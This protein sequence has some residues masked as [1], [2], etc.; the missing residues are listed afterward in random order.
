MKKKGFLLA[1]L[2]VLFAFSLAIAACSHVKTPQVEVETGGVPC[3]EFEITAPALQAEGVG[4]NPLICW[5]AE[6]N[7][8]KYVVS[9]CK[10]T[11]FSDIAAE[12]V[13]KE[14]SVTLSETLAYST[15]YYIRIFAVKS[16]E[17]GNDIILSYASSVFTTLADHD[18]PVPDNSR[19]R[20]IHDFENFEDDSELQNFFTVHTGG[21]SLIPTLA[22]GEGADGSTAMRL[23]YT[24]EGNGWS[25]VQ[26]INP[27]D[28]KNWSGAT[29]IRL[30]ISSPGNGGVLSVSIG[31][32]GYQTWK[33]SVTLN[34]K[35]AA[36]VSIPFSAFEDSGGGDG[37][38]D[39]TGIVRLWF[40][41]K[42]NAASEV[43]L[44]NISIGSD[45]LHSE[46]TRSVFEQGDVM[47]VGMYDDFE[48]Y[49]SADAVKE[50]YFFNLIDPDSI[51]LE[52][53][54]AFS[55]EQMLGFVPNEASVA[56]GVRFGGKADFSDIVSMRFKASAGSYSVQFVSGSNVMVASVLAV[57]NGE[58]VGVNLDELD[59]R[60]PS[61]MKMTLDLVDYIQIVVNGKKNQTVYIDDIEFSAERFVPADHSAPRTL[62]DFENYADDTALQGE[63]YANASG[64]A[65]T[66]TLA[67]GEGAQG[68]TAMQVR[69]GANTA[70][71][72]ALQS[73]LSDGRNIWVGAEGIR[74]WIDGG[75]SGITV[76]VRI[77][78]T[79]NDLRAKL[80]LNAK[81]GQYVSI[82]F[83]AFD[84]NAGSRPSDFSSVSVLW[85]YVSGAEN[86]TF[87][88]D[89]ISIGSGEGY[90]ADT[91]DSVTNPP[92][93]SAEGI[94]EDFEGYSAAGDVTGKWTVSGS[95]AP[96]L[97]TKNESQ[98]LKFYATKEFSAAASGYGLS[99]Y[100]FTDING[101][102]FRLGIFYGQGASSATVTVR[103]GSEGNYYTVNKLFFEM[104]NNN[105]TYMV[106]DF[107]GMTLA[108]G[109]AGELDSSAIDFLEISVSGFT[110]VVDF[111]ID[112]LE[113][114]TDAVG[115]KG[116][117]FTSDFS[118]DSTQNW[119]NAVIANNTAT[120]SSGSLQ[121][122]NSSWA[123]YQNTYALRFRV[124][125]QN[126]V[127]IS[128][129]TL[130]GS[131]DG[132]TATIPIGE[133]G[134][135]EFIVYY[136]QM[137]VRNAMY[138]SM[139]FY[140]IQM[141]VTF[142]TGGGSAE[143]SS[144]ELLIG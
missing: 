92:K 78:D 68:S 91:R 84:V 55:G 20:V 53:G 3:G 38:W 5:T 131:G 56:F 22:K 2:G 51:A 14:T 31:K 7:A 27:A 65:L 6:R 29:G 45:E 110:G 46:D 125:T 134:E 102:R 140:Y 71:W 74:F 26:S 114:Y 16:D 57:S 9:L 79:A 143:F 139:K 123:N 41:Y 80:T 127:S 97:V 40:Y 10:D 21:D 101:F 19:T 81:E 63:F 121:Y 99:G 52:S 85:L 48:S 44:D 90:D 128:A 50:R 23:T 39:M 24:P 17:N 60:D 106:C 82:P 77:G 75:G 43:L 72:A 4:V 67:D 28:K 34:K 54:N 87:L 88:I 36:Y 130:N 108:D 100:D 76:T 32:R 135:Y 144:V 116:A 47:P 133:D 115:A 30:W 86:S 93:G 35:G 89:D 109:S 111:W 141:Y 58:S 129:R 120:I 94:L 112:D 98:V 95:A 11:S 62:Y 66:V 70:G 33:A 119:G 37:F 8:E 64:N 83:S 96:S 15:K 25:A 142:G 124:K 118:D 132:K 113:F 137:D 104:A 138:T 18:T 73:R 105:A 69:L 122:T 126:V 49:T 61:T 1:A 12:E 117:A 107:A 103:I 13:T 59:L 42:A 136:D